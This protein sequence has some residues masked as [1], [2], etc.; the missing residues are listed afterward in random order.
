MDREIKLGTN[1]FY[2]GE[3]EDQALARITWTPKDEQHIDV[4]STYTDD[5]LRGQGI[6]ARLM[7]A[8]VTYARENDLKII[9]TCSYVVHKM[10]RNPDE[11]SDIRA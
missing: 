5:Q 7:D 3:S 11:Y 6:A 1:C 4:D 9:P 2:I 10:D 8:V